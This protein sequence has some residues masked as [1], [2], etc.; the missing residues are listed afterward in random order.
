MKAVT[1]VRDTLLP[2]DT[3]SPLNSI[4]GLDFSTGSGALRMKFNVEDPYNRTLIMRLKAEVFNDSS[5]TIIETIPESTHTYTVGNTGTGDDFNL[6]TEFNIDFAFTSAFLSDDP[7]RASSAVGFVANRI[8]ISGSL[9]AEDGSDPGFVETD[10]IDIDLVQEKEA[11]NID[12]FL[13]LASFGEDQVTSAQTLSTTSEALFENAFYVILQDQTT[14]ANPVNWAS[15]PEVDPSVRGLIE[16]FVPASGI[17]NDVA[18]APE[19]VLWDT[20]TNAPVVGI[21]IELNSGPLLE[22]SSLAENLPQRNTYSYNIIFENPNEAFSGLAIG[23][24]RFV[25]LRVNA[26]DRSGNQSNDTAQI[27]FFKEANPYMRDGSTSWLSIDTRVFHVLEGDTI[28]GETINNS[29][30]PNTLIQSFI[31]KLNSGTGLGGDTFDGLPT[32]Q[33]Q[34]A[35]YPFGTITDQTTSTTK[36]VHN[37]ALAKVRLQGN[38][39]AANVRAFFRLFR[40]SASNLIFDSSDHYRTHDAGGGAKISLLGYSGASP[41]DELVSV[42]FFALPRVATN[43]AMTSQIDTPNVQDFPSGIASEQVLYFGVYL[44]I[45]QSG[46][47][48]PSSY[49]PAHPDGGFT[50]ADPTQSLPTLMLD[51]HQ[52]MVVE[53]N[54]D[55]DPTV[56]GDTPAL[57]DNLAQR[58]L[59]ILTTDNPGAPITHSVQHS[60]EMHLGKRN[61]N[62]NP[63]IN[64]SHNLKNHVKLQDPVIRGLHF[65][66]KGNFEKR[67]KDE[68]M[69]LAMN[70]RNASMMEW[71]KFVPQAESEIRKANTLIFDNAR[72]SGTSLWADELMIRWNNIPPGSQ[73]KIY[74]PNIN[75]ENVLNLRNLRHAPADVKII[76]SHT[77]IL[78]AND[79]TY[80]PIP[81]VK[82]IKVAGAITIELPEG[83]KKG[84]N[85]KVDVIHLRGGKQQV[86]GGFQIDIQVKVAKE[87]HAFESQLLKH[88]FGQLSLTAPNNRWHPVLQ[89]RVNTLRERAKA[90][91]ESAGEDW[92]DPTTY[93][94]PNDSNNPKPFE[95]QKLRVVLEKIQILDDLDTFI[96]GKGEFFF[97]CH[98]YSSNNRGQ[99]AKNRLPEK[100][101][102][103]VSDKPGKNI[104]PLECVIFEGFVV[105]DLRIEIL[106]TE[107][108][109]FDPNDTLGKYSRIFC[110]KVTQMYGMYGPNKEEV[111]DP[112]NLVSW[113][114]WYRIE[115]C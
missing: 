86:V 83:I 24:D 63:K 101:I 64:L 59:M 60:F 49:I 70:D 22:D 32:N 102:F 66:S 20:I 7:T 75:C 52:C 44:D 74:L 12:L 55:G 10:F 108:D 27:K 99:S 57:S 61:F 26:Y 53:I 82:R 94:D 80:L 40:Y 92:V 6:N 48:F 14:D 29:T 39:G 42:P 5:V 47:R 105:D 65:L 15:F 88:V 23:A 85:W 114:V 89:Y 43:T 19:V 58:N 91:A 112:E 33:A 71:E 98:V 81:S 93:I 79:V 17:F 56:V 37:F 77:L 111:I 13:D 107:K 90:L 109:L 21:R 73:A 103:K 18:H 54:Y 36:K 104:L 84:Q 2:N 78:S 45:N 51:H 31:N 96:K 76:D 87:I 16:G 25:E 100:G 38:S 35:L 41:T 95:G 113:K 69:N 115:R 50:G 46:V 4:S 3:V 34:S 106:G 8:R 1:I 68:A 9:T 97:Q 67:V 62:N 72:W 110:K 11:P 30:N 28:F